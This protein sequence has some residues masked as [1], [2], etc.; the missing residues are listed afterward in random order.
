MPAS[1]GLPVQCSRASAGRVS[2]GAFW[3]MCQRQ[4]LCLRS[5]VDCDSTNRQ[6]RAAGKARTSD[7]NK[8]RKEARAQASGAPG[9]GQGAGITFLPHT[10]DAVPRGMCASCTGRA[11]RSEGPGVCIS[12]PPP[13]GRND[14]KF[15]HKGGIPPEG[16][17][18]CAEAHVL[19]GQRSSG[20]S[21]PPF[22]WQQRP[23]GSDTRRHERKGAS[24][25]HTRGGSSVVS[26]TG[27]LPATTRALG[28]GSTQS[29]TSI[30]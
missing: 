30:G 21:Q 14:R 12:S 20:M 4:R 10:A 1:L 7:Q 25:S 16:C 26:E 2:T 17:G 19:A 3:T 23:T 28:S 9:H 18:W 6:P 15:P 13:G 11:D 24:R 5:S 22:E 27:P 8:L 29:E